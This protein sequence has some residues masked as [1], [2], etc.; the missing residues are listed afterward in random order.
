MYLRLK[1]VNNPPTITPELLIRC[2]LWHDAFPDIEAITDTICQHITAYVPLHD[3]FS[4][5]E[6]SV[7]LTDDAEI[8]QLNREYRDKDKPTN[9]LS[10]PLFDHDMPLDQLFGGEAFE[11]GIT[12]G[13][14]VIS[15]DTIQKEAGEQNKLLNDHYAH[16]LIHGI[17][18]LFGYDHI[19][20]EDAE[21]MESLEVD[22][23]KFLSISNPY[24]N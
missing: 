16:M 20:A 13:D 21:Q 4:V 6:I 7:L 1:K 15:F 23:L 14:V 2:S 18:H 11:G 19:E 3:A 10:F 24:D 22:I 5:Y 17:L 8:Q 12:V 9:V